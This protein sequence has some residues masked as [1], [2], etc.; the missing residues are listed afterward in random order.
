LLLFYT[1]NTPRRRTILRGSLHTCGAHRTDI[2]YPVKAIKIVRAQDGSILSWELSTDKP[3]DVR[4]YL[5]WPRCRWRVS[6]QP[7][8][9]IGIVS[10]R[11][12]STKQAFERT[13]EGESYFLLSNRKKDIHSFTECGKTAAPRRNI[14]AALMTVDSASMAAIALNGFVSRLKDNLVIRGRC[15]CVCLRRRQSANASPR[16]IEFAR[17]PRPQ[18]GCTGLS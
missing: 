15:E 6:I 4:G 14:G 8:C 16:Q 10:K 9:N 7:S 11:F 12:T 5:L 18:R 17:V 13:L 1:G 2:Q 3:L